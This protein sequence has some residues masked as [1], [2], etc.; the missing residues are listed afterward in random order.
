MNNYLKKVKEFMELGGQDIHN[1]PTLSTDSIQGLRLN[2]INEEL[3]ELRQALMSNDIIE[4][5]DALIDLQYVLSGAILA[6][7]MQDIF[8]REFENVD[9]NNKTKFHTSF[10]EACK[11]VDFYTNNGQEDF[12]IK[13]VIVNDTKYFVVCHPNGKIQKPYN[14]EKVIL[15]LEV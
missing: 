12:T 6:F 9:T 3:K 10:E 8:D 5:L 1:F 14:Y 4:T 2:L 13:E 11:T 15:N 7:G